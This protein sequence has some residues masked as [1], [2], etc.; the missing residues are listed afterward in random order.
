LEGVLIKGI[1]G[2]GNQDAGYP[3][4]WISGKRS[5][6][7]MGRHGGKILFTTSPILRVVDF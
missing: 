4:T 1:S 5:D 3:D 7:E 6:P 2:S